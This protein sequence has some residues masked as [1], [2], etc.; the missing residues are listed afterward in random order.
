VISAEEVDANYAE[1]SAQIDRLEELEMPAW[2]GT[3]VGSQKPEAV[4]PAPR[5]I[6]C[7]YFLRFDVEF[8]PGHCHRHAPT[9]GKRGTAQWPSV[10]GEYWCGDFEEVCEASTLAAADRRA[11]PSGFWA[12]VLG[13]FRG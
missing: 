13:W 11:A 5:C 10:W 7:R 3:E 2:S 4:A 6:G 1:L 8:D 9:A 12:R